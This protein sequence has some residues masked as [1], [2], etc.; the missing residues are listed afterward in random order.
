[1]YKKNLVSIIVPIYNSE[2]NLER[3]ISSII[4]QSYQNI[5]IILIDDGSTD[6]SREICYNFVMKDK[7]INYFFQENKGVSAA[8]NYGLEKVHGEFLLFIDSDDWIELNCIEICLNYI[9][10]YNADIVK[11]GYYIEKNNSEPKINSNKKLSQFKTIENLL[12]YC[13]NTKYYAFVWNMFIRREK[14]IKLKFLKDIN[15]LE[16]QIFGYCCFLCTGLKLFV[17]DTLYHYSFWDIGSL[18]NVKKPEI[19]LKS[20]KIEYHLKK[21]LCKLNPLYL[22]VI[23][24]EYGWRLEYLIK[25]LYVKYYSNSFKKRILKSIKHKSPLLSI[26][27]KI[28]FNNYLPFVIKNILISLIYFIKNTRELKRIDI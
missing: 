3:C 19:I 4:K 23:E 26:V 13:D 5:E 10:S 8:R 6:N 17:P 9:L 24:L 12:E 27:S 1:M 14:I 21:T 2:R 7:R 18:S 28:F 20:L 11:F 15:W 16:D 22:Q 25:S